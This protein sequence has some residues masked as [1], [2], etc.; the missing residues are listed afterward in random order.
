MPGTDSVDVNNN[1]RPHTGDDTDSAAKK[2]KNVPEPYLIKFSQSAGVAGNTEGVCA[3]LSTL[4]AMAALEKGKDG[5]E[6]LIKN[7]EKTSTRNKITFDRNNFLDQIKGSIAHFQKEV[8]GNKGAFSSSSKNKNEKISIDDIY[9]Q[10]ERTEKST[11]Y[12]FS[13]GNHAMLLTVLVNDGIKTFHFF[14][15][16]S[17]AVG[18]YSDMAS[19]KKM[20]N[21]YFDFDY[22]E[23]ISKEIKN[24]KENVNSGVL[25]KEIQ[26]KSGNIIIEV[27]SSGA[28]IQ[29]SFYPSELKDSI[30]NFKIV[31]TKYRDLNEFTQAVFKVSHS[32]KESFSFEKA[33]NDADLISETLKNTEVKHGNSKIIEIGGKR[34]VKQTEKLTSTYQVKSKE[35][36]IIFSGA[37]ENLR[38]Y[39]VQVDTHNNRRSNNLLTSYEVPVEKGK[40][41]F[42]FKSINGV[43]SF[44]NKKLSMV[45][46]MSLSDLYKKDLPGTKKAALDPNRVYDI[47]IDVDLINAQDRYLDIEDNLLNKRNTDTNR[48]DFLK[49]KTNISGIEIPGYTADMSLEGM[50]KL[51]DTLN[52]SANFK[53]LGALS[54]HIDVAHSQQAAR[55]KVY[56]D[57]QDSD[58][59]K[60]IIDIMAKVA[61]DSN[62]IVSMRRLSQSAMLF[63]NVDSDTSGRCY[64]I[65]NAA[66]VAL[67][68]GG[69][70]ALEQ[71]FVNMDN[72]AN[73]PLS[74]NAFLFKDSLASLQASAENDYEARTNSDKKATHTLEQVSI[75][76]DRAAETGQ[77]TSFEFATRDHMMQVS[78]VVE[79]GK[80]QYL[81]VDS[82][83]IYFKSSTSNGLTASIA[84]YFTSLN[85]S[86]LPNYG[87]DTPATHQFEFKKQD[88]KTLGSLPI[89]DTLLRPADLSSTYRLSRLLNE[90]ML[91][92]DAQVIDGNNGVIKP[93]VDAGITHKDLYIAQTMLSGKQDAELFK[94][95]FTDDVYQSAQLDKGKYLVNGASVKKL[96]NNQYEIEFIDLEKVRSS[97]AN[98]NALTVDNPISKKTITVSNSAAIDRYVS[99]R[100]KLSLKKNNGLKVDGMDAAD[101]YFTLKGFVDG[102]GGWS[103]YDPDK[104]FHA[105]VNNTQLVSGLTFTGAQLFNQGYVLAKNLKPEMWGLS[106]IGKFNNVVGK[107]RKF[108]PAIGT[109]LEGVNLYYHIRDANQANDSVMKG[110]AITQATISSASIAVGATAT[111]AMAVG[112]IAAKLGAAGIAAGAATAGTV[113][114]VAGMVLLPVAIGAGVAISSILETH[115]GAKGLVELL[116]SLNLLHDAVNKGGFELKDGIL[117]A[118]NG[119]IVKKMDFVNNK[120]TLDGHQFYDASNKCNQNASHG[121]NS[122]SRSLNELLG[123]NT[124]QDLGNGTNV[125]LPATL[126]TKSHFIFSDFIAS[127]NRDLNDRLSGGGK[128][129]IINNYDKGRLYDKFY[130]KSRYLVDYYYDG[131]YHSSTISSRDMDISG[132]HTET[133]FE[134]TQVDVI[135]D[136]QA[137][138]FYVPELTEHY[139]NIFTY[140]FEGGGGN[141]TIALQAGAVINLLESVDLRGANVDPSKKSNWILDARGLEASDI[142]IEQGKLVISGLT[143]NIDPSI[144]GGKIVVIKKNGDICRIDPSTKKQILTQTSGWTGSVPAGYEV[145]RYVA[146]KDYMHQGVN[147][148]N[149]FY[150]ASTQKVVFTT[151]NESHQPTELIETLKSL[152]KSPCFKARKYIHGGYHTYSGAG[153]GGGCSARVQSYRSS[154]ELE[155]QNLKLIT[156]LQNLISK[157]ENGAYKSVVSGEDALYKKAKLWLENRLTFVNTLSQDVKS[158][159]EYIW[160]EDKSGGWTSYNNKFDGGHIEFPVLL[161]DSVNLQQ[162]KDLENG[163]QT[164]SWEAGHS[165]LLQNAQLGAVVGDDVYWYNT[166]EG[167]IWRTD[168]TTGDIKAQYVF[169]SSEFLF[170]GGKDI[171]FQY[172]SINN[173]GFEQQNNKL[174]VSL[175]LQQIKNG[176][177]HSKLI[178]HLDPDT[179]KLVSVHK[180]SGPKIEQLECKR[181]AFG[182]T[183]NTIKPQEAPLVFYYNDISANNRTLYW[184]RNGNEK[185]IP[186]LAKDQL[187]A[188][189]VL[190]SSMKGDH[191]T[192]V[193]YFF[194]PLKKEL[195]RQEGLTSNLMATKIGDKKVLTTIEQTIG[196]HN[197]FILTENNVLKQVNSSGTLTSVELNK[198]LLIGQIPLW[199]TIKFP[200]V[201]FVSVLKAGDEWNLVTDDGVRI[202]LDSV[203]KATLVG[204]NQAWLDAKANN[205]ST[206]ISSLIA[207]NNLSHGEVIAL[208]DNNNGLRRW[209]H[210][211]LKQTIEAFWNT[212]DK[213]PAYIGTETKSD[214]S[215][216]VHIAS[217]ER[218]F[219]HDYDTNG[220]EIINDGGANVRYRWK[221]YEAVHT[222]RVGETLTLVGSNGDDT[223]DPVLVQGVN[224]AVMSGGEGKDTYDLTA[225]PKKQLGHIIVN[226]FSIDRKIDVLKLA[227]TDKAMLSRGANDN[228]NQSIT[229]NDLLIMQEGKLVVLKNVFASDKADYNHMELHANN[230]KYDVAYLV[231]RFEQD[232]RSGFQNTYYGLS[233]FDT[234]Q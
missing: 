96:S 180:S 233:S 114:G 131:N 188:S 195:F 194:D 61:N 105:I 177:E 20:L 196:D 181:F 13:T 16:N 67:E 132:L 171:S 118:L 23:T 135:L 143:V 10:L 18:N 47:A 91:Q 150:D 8:T 172:W 70:K 104:H 207:N 227:N 101:L 176:C 156:S 193:F 126:K 64:G 35:N 133:I 40:H 190:A 174:L 22:Y 163:L 34:F 147:V 210:V 160:S 151:T 148:G 169:D 162:I 165:G 36:R 138:V 90:R 117:Y 71:L 76:L 26:T 183:T 192:E 140:A 186:N 134:K 224:S 175:D 92:Q 30:N 97:A 25:L 103:T 161:K 199:L 197:L 46:K 122:A 83:G 178:Y 157:W 6:Q 222:Q 50:Y 31:P 191:G 51:A 139:K 136:H 60:K 115:N 185:I 149:A 167:L 32:I 112:A 121:S 69:I 17:K 11:A 229:K 219:M 184:L 211:D 98:I 204:F 39:L 85:D 153:G 68:S 15:S 198:L 95:A 182:A 113:A 59:N 81:F 206:S 78:V 166:Q 86:K 42:Y 62:G 231:D 124:E 170:K 3:G 54:N 7:L 24:L 88:T 145:E 187:N 158:K 144:V 37:I 28:D 1:K 12:G 102:S 220:K 127:N 154:Y 108:L 214:G 146:I 53:A 5:I 99:N 130:D 216:T 109:A 106:G 168:K 87:V 44:K 173:I 72:T 111:G 66:A 202:R 125:V 225:D 142:R 79:N 63:A 110:V 152:T 49:A 93:L 212:K 77:T 208:P 209:Y 179:I 45:D 84:K 218:H 27:F 221:S 73:N 137:R 52:D 57:Q 141:T 128:Q 38:D 230:Q 155:E 74:K 232:T 75:N 33:Y 9:S 94:H 107:M 55:N 56:F 29:Y 203:G 48:Q 43:D 201:K 159:T 223:L 119:A 82:N 21:E 65:T 41:H 19:F 164:L 129:N 80:K 58:L 116:T 123:I 120:A 200:L 100:E 215:K 2:N 213:H 205:L 4:V 89:G 217:S 189:L 14:D 234:L 228:L 226:N